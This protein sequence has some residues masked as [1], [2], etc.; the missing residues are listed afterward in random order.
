MGKFIIWLLSS[1]GVY[2]LVTKITDKAKKG[3]KKKKK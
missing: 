1:I 3:T 2:S